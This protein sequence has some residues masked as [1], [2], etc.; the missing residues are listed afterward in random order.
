VRATIAQIID[1]DLAEVPPEPL[2]QVFWYAAG[3]SISKRDV[4]LP[5]RGVTG[6]AA[7]CCPNVSAAMRWVLRGDRFVQVS[8]PE[9]ET[10]GLSQGRSQRSLR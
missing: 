10:T 8:E 2:A 5:S 7:I 4:L 9:H 1:P 6:A 3:F